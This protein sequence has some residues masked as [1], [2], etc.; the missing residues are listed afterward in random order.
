M[1]WFL[2]AFGA[3]FLWAIVNIADNYLVAKYSQ[4]EKER[5]SGGLVLFSSLIGIVMAL[6]IGIFTSNIFN[7]ILVDKLLLLMAG[8]LSVVWIIL[9]LYA[10][11]IEDIS[12]I[13]PWFLTIPIFGYILGYIFLGEV[14]SAKQILGSIVILLGLMLISVDFFN[15][16]KSI[17]KRT[18]IY[19]LL[20]SIIVAI[21]GIIF[22][23]VTIEGNFWVSSF[24][25]YLGLGS[26]GLI[27]YIFVPKYRREFMYMH[28]MGGRK[29][30]IVNIIS[31]L[32]TIG[33]NLMTNFALLLAPVSMVYLVGSFQPAIV[34]FLTI[35]GTKFFPHIINE[36]ISKKVILQKIISIIIMIVGSIFLFV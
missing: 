3:P 15:L 27:L 32:M 2:L 23:Y 22:K 8:G 17:K 1:N 24:W 28:K 19:I 30:F 26:I 13:V 11:E 33:G 34:L 20:A 31:E 10:I 9:Y 7:I 5:S 25:E 14:L 12:V 6:I 4:K 18:I 29:I 35:I 16:K 36:N 21:S